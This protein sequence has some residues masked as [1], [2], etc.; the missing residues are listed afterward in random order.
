MTPKTAHPPLK[1]EKNLLDEIQSTATEE[2]V[3]A[4]YARAIASKQRINWKR[5]NAAIIA[6]WSRTRLIE[7]KSNAWKLMGREG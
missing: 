6:R 4:M 5:V 7:I 2:D 3:T 1:I